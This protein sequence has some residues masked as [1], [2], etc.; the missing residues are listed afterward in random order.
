MEML[1]SAFSPTY[2]AQQNR[3]T[4][5][6]LRQNNSV[7]LWSLEPHEGEPAVFGPT[8]AGWL[9]TFGGSADRNIKTTL[10]N[11]RAAKQHVRSVDAP[12]DGGHGIIRRSLDAVILCWLRKW[13][14]ITSKRH[15]TLWIHN[16]SRNV[17]T[18][19]LIENKSSCLSRLKKVKNCLKRS[20][21]G[22]ASQWNVALLVLVSCFTC[23]RVFNLKLDKCTLRL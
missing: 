3:I 2:T 7:K 4:H 6:A 19:Y 1:D 23:M 15:D 14:Q 12:P 8:G 11:H 18:R 20:S 22:S 21:A 9:Q 5:R 16:E 10:T 17:C 13:V